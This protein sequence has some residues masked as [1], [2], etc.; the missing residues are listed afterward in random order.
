MT[1]IGTAAAMT[2]ILGVSSVGI[3]FFSSMAYEILHEMKH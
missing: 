3:A 1:I 2:F